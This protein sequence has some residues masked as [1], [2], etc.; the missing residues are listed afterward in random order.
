MTRFAITLTLLATMS[1]VGAVDAATVV[2]NETDAKGGDY[3][4][5]HRNPTVFG[6]DVA[7]VTGSQNRKSDVDW[8]VFDGFARGTERLE[9]TFT[10]VGGDWGGLSLRLKDEAFKHAWDSWP[11]LDAWYLDGISDDRSV[12]VSYVLDGYTGPVYARLDFYHGNDLANGTGLSYSISRIGDAYLPEAGAAPAPVPL[13]APGALAL[14][15]LA[16]LAALRR[17]RRG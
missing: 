14:A 11:L 13:P 12:T 15:G 2:A 3:S 16:A 1:L 10:N 5:S 7:L 17:R 6:Q 4:N 8:L 9:F